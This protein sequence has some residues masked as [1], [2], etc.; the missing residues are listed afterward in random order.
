VRMCVQTRE[1]A[2]A[3]H[4]SVDRSS[5]VSHAPRCKSTTDLCNSHRDK[6]S[7]PTPLVPI[8]SHEWMHMLLLANYIGC[9]HLY[10]A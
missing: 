5:R 7:V 9:N 2:K 10:D 6:H 4:N 1:Y 3:T 8:Y